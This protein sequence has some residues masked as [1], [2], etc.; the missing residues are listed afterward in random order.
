M[1]V[2]QEEALSRPEGQKVEEKEDPFATCEFGS[3]DMLRTGTRIGEWSLVV[4]VL[5]KG[6]CYKSP[7]D[8]LP[9]LR[10]A[11]SEVVRWEEEHKAAKQARVRSA[12]GHFSGPD[13]PIGRGP[14]PPP[15]TSAMPGAERTGGDIAATASSLELGEAERED[16]DA[17]SRR[18]K[19]LLRAMFSAEAAI[20]LL[21]QCLDIYT[22]DDFQ[23][24]CFDLNNSWA[25]DE[26]YD[27]Q[28][29]S[30]DR[31]CLSRGFGVV[32][33]RFGF[34]PDDKGTKEIEAIISEL[35]TQ[36]QGVSEKQN[37]V[38]RILFEHF[39]RLG[40][41]SMTPVRG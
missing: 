22:T 16:P 15:V 35:S 38:R 9:F 10:G 33:E 29:R 40:N 39:P 2:E 25:R 5:W 32:L 20:S 3:W 17:P 4:D 27:A 26:K 1:A 6:L 23:A 12:F 8:L 37:E 7:L 24:A 11:L 30:I 36:D 28:V 19:R 41:A 13:K 21:T 18:W 34:T 14:G 31:L